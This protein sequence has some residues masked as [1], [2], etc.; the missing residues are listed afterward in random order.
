MDAGA[1]P[2]SPKDKVLRDD[3]NH[4]GQRKARNSDLTSDSLE[5]KDLVPEQE[6][7]L[8]LLVP[9]NPLK[10]DIEAGKAQSYSTPQG[11]FRLTSLAALPA[12]CIPTPLVIFPPAIPAAC[13][14]PV[15]PRD[16]GKLGGSLQEP[17]MQST[18]LIF[19]QLLW[20]TVPIV[21]SPPLVRL[22]LA[23]T[24]PV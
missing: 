20:P 9:G 4:K 24:S 21:I 2:H 8:L 15:L 13:P 14:P 22:H 3:E 1:A 5:D 17:A 19:Q 16:G 6:A 10:V 23:P 7:P 18:S 12:F 11:D